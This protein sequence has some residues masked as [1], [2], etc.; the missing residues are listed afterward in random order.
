MSSLY[1]GPPQLKIH[2]PSYR[3]LLPLAPLLRRSVFHS[4][5]LTGLYYRTKCLSCV[6]LFDPT[7][8]RP[9]NKKNLNFISHYFP[10]V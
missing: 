5:S 6:S 10:E 1:E 7:F 9:C 2:W 3:V 4:S 8:H